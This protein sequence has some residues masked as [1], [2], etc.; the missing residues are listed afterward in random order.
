MGA[1]GKYLDFLWNSFQYDITVF[2]HGWLYYWLLIPAIGY[3]AFF[4]LKWVF[5]TVPLWMPFAILVRL[6]NPPVPNCRNCAYRT[7][8]DIEPGA[9]ER[10]ELTGY[11][12]EPKSQAIIEP[13]EDT[14]SKSSS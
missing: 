1:I 14:D 6:F 4:V 7:I 2:S 10:E 8:I 12:E 5:L 9:E 13:G 3:A 11:T